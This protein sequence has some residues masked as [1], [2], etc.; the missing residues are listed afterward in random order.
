MFGRAKDQEPWRQSHIGGKLGWA[1]AVDHGEDGEKEGSCLPRASLGTRHQVSLAHDDRQSVLLD[2]SGVLVLRHLGRGKEENLTLISIE[3]ANWN[4][5]LKYLDINN[6][7]IQCNIHNVHAYTHLN[8]I[9]S[10]F[11]KVAFIKVGD[12]LGAALPSSLHWDVLILVKVDAC[13]GISKQ[14]TAQSVG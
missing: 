7:H 2:W 12:I 3:I 14:F 9:A 5:S 1:V 13:I 10:N 4:T 8:V 6:I 11:V